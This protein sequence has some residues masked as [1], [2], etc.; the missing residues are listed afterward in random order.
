MV[1]PCVIGQTLVLHHLIGVGRLRSTTCAI[2]QLFRFDL[3]G[4][5]CYWAAVFIQSVQKLWIACSACTHST[6]LTAISKEH[7]A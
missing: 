5:L 3:A 2:R 6:L 4:A 7:S 1:E